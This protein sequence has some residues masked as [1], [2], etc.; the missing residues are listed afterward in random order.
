MS[1]TT[2]SFPEKIIADSWART[3][4]YNSVSD[5][6][7]YC[8]LWRAY[9]QARQHKRRTVNQLEFELNLERNLY[10]LYLDIKN[11]CYQLSPSIA[12][13]IYDPKTREIFAA[14]FRDRIV[15]HLVYNYIAPYWDKH[16][17]YDSYSCRDNK[18]I[19]F[20]AQRMTY[21]LRCVTNDFTSEA[22]VMKLDITGYFMNINRQ[23]M[24]Q[25]VKRCL[26]SSSLG[27]PPVVVNLLHYLLS[28]IIFADPTQTAILKGGYSEWRTLPVNKSLFLTKSDCGFPIGNLTSQLF[29]N[30]YL[31]E[32]DMFVKHQLKIR[33]Y[34]RYVDD[35]VLMHQ[36]KKILLHAK[37]KIARFLQQH[38]HLSLHCGKVYL[39]L[40]KYGLTFVGAVIRPHRVFP[41]QR[42]RKNRQRFLYLTR[43]H[44]HDDRWENR[45]QSY[46]GLVSAYRHL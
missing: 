7:L 3:S 23:L 8:D 16:F 27:Q 13:I 38:L 18:G 40:A 22:W 2:Q 34:G 1:A 20:G 30:I 44:H 46:C 37:K 33:Y 39:Q 28:I 14:S 15:H 36:C 41:T 11:R 45:W 19:H 42:L 43:R 12:F 32:L 9:Y 35:F 17:I 6:W 26:H 31:H 10:Q 21:F 29:S 25:L 4:S 5:Y 24:W